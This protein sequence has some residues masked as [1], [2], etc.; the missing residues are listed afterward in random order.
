MSP[1]IDR[2]YAEA[3]TGAVVDD[4][5]AVPVLGSVIS[6]VFSVAAS[7]V[8]VVVVV[9]GFSASAVVAVAS[10]ATGAASVAF[11]SVSLG[12]AGGAEASFTGPD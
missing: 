1:S 3:V 4:A 7:G 6:V 8:S 2:V 5:A 10:L 9:A 12:G 11:V